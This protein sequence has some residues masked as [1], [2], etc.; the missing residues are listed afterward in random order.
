MTKR[1]L[2]M[3]TIALGISTS[4][5]AS[6]WSLAVTVLTSITPAVGMRNTMVR[7]SDIGSGTV[8]DVKPAASGPGGWV[9]VL[10][11]DHVISPAMPH[12]ISFGD[13]GGGGAS[14]AAMV[15][16]GPL[17]PDTSLT[18]ALLLHGSRTCPLFLP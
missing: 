10:T 16:R 3:R 13:A 5:V 17:N 8:I 12:Y 15:M 6:G 9:C 18:S 14:Y 4:L 7:V 11:A 2:S 1:T